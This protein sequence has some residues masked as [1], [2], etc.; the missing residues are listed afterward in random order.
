M[1]AAYDAFWKDARPLMVNETAPM[2]PTR[3]F[4]ELYEKQLKHGGIPDWKAPEF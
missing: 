1:N 2:S 3:P 4:F